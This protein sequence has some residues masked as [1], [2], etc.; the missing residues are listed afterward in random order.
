MSFASSKARFILSTRRRYSGRVEMWVRTFGWFGVVGVCSSLLYAFG[1]TVGATWLGLPAQAANVLGFTLSALCSYF[2]HRRLTFR[3]ENRHRESAPKFLLQVMLGYMLSSALT[4]LCSYF[5]VYYVF[6]II[7]VIVF[8]PAF[9][10]I[11][12]KFW[13]FSK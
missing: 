2:G 6:N 7:I 12:F 11:V 13:V 8:L 9:N 5:D 4:A 3:A 1:M 10:F